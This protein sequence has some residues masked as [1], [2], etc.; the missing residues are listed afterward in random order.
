VHRQGAVRIQD[1]GEK[2]E[3]GWRRRRFTGVKKFLF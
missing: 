1:C 2:A 3:E